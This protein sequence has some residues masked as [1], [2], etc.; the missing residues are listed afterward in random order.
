MTGL[1]ALTAACL[2]DPDDEGRLAVL[3]DWLEEHGDARADAVRRVLRWRAL[4][5]AARAEE[6]PD[7]C[8]DYVALLRSTALAL[9][10]AEARLWA[11]ACLRRLPLLQAGAGP[12]LLADPHRRRVVAAVELFACGLLSADRLRAVRAAELSPGGGRREA[13]P[14]RIVVWSVAEPDLGRALRELL[15]AAVL[16][17]GADGGRFGRG[18]SLARQAVAAAD[19]MLRGRRGRGP[20][21][22]G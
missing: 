4:V 22:G 1:D 13:D 2:D 14:G 19:R 11:C 15:G 20:G 18:P 3:S 5:A 17:L 21:D 12:A 6:V 10:Q 7:D 9:G 8:E 16:F